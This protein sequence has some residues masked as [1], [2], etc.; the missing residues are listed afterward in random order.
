MDRP[1]F[2]DDMDEED[3]YFYVLVAV[4]TSIVIAVC[5][6]VGFCYCC[7][8]NCRNKCENREQVQQAGT[9]S[10]GQRQ[11]IQSQIPTSAT[12]VFDARVAGTMENTPSA[13]RSNDDPPPSYEECMQK[14]P[15]YHFDESGCVTYSERFSD[16]TKSN[17]ENK[18]TQL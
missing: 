17:N 6:C 1:I 12:N 2:C 13:Q 3:P 11:L 7:Y 16:E 5:V 15:A 18:T 10:D 8:T 14:P 4:V 9:S